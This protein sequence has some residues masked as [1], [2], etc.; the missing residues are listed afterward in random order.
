MKKLYDGFLKIMER[1]HK[2]Q[3][4]E[5][6]DRGNAVNVLLVKPGATPEEDVFYFGRQY[7]A[8]PNRKIYGN[9]AGMIDKGESAASAAIR[10]AKEE[11]GARGKLVYIDTRYNSPG[12]STSKT[13]FFVMVVKNWSEPT[14]K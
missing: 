5:V 6:M 2:G 12:D 4:Y 11:A 7:R 3:P 10:E 9:V 14:D 13:I 8:G 1:V